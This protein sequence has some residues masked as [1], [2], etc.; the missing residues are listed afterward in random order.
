MCVCVWSPTLISLCQA[1]YTHKH[2]KEPPAVSQHVTQAW[3]MSH[4]RERERERG[5]ASKRE[6]EGEREGERQRERERERRERDRESGR[7][8]DR[9][10]YT[11]RWK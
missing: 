5:R 4:R 1:C 10:W 7:E 8:L 6:R 2:L 11:H 9:D 3:Q